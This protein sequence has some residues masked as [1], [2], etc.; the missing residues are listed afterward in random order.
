MSALRDLLEEAYEAF[1]AHD[2]ARLR[3]LF[4]DEATWPN[5]LDDCGDPVGKEAVLAYFARIFA[6]IIPNIQLIDVVEETADSLTTDAQ[7][8]VETREG[9]IWTDTRARLV[10]HFRDGLLVGQT[11]L[12]GF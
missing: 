2:A 3:P 4:H 9:H 8:S 5:T 6:T 1:N 12:D 7:Y 11:I 10:Y